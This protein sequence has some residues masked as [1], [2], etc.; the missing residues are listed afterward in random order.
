[1]DGPRYLVSLYFKKEMEFHKL[2]D[3]L[4]ST[5]DQHDWDDFWNNGSL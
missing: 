5:V 3:L 4:I 2:R 1:M